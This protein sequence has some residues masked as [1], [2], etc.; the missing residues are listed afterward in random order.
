MLKSIIVQRIM[1][2]LDAAVLGF[3]IDRISESPL[4]GVLVA[5]IAGGTGLFLLSN[6]VLQK[7]KENLDAGF[8]P[9]IVTIL[10]STTLALIFFIECAVA[11]WLILA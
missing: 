10:R 8:D 3:I 6:T 2:V 7:T 1:V 5:V 4:W 9:E 11:T